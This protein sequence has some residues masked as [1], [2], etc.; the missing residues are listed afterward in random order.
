MSFCAFLAVFF[1]WL[2]S[3]SLFF[4]YFYVAA[5]PCARSMSE[6]YHQ[7]VFAIRKEIK[8][9]VMGSSVFSL[10]TIMYDRDGQLH[11]RLLYGPLASIL[12]RMFL[13]HNNF[14]CEGEAVLRILL[15]TCVGCTPLLLLVLLSR[16]YI[17]YEV[18]EVFLVFFFFIFYLWCVSGTSRIFFFEICL[19]DSIALWCSCRHG[20]NGGTCVASI[21]LPSS[22]RR[23]KNKDTVLLFDKFSDRSMCAWLFS[24]FFLY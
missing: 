15:L 7:R 8:I 12:I 10:C 1:C 4:S 24:T 22:C 21:F 16:A 18:C 19:G 2:D 3:V 13:T 6:R 9:C 23:Q 5:G 11:M 20:L 17:I 14:G